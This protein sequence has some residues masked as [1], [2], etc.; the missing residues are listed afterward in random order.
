MR[1]RAMFTVW[2]KRGCEGSG[3]GPSHPAARCVLY[4][5]RVSSKESGLVAV[6]RNLHSQLPLALELRYTHTLHKHT[7]YKLWLIFP[8]DDFLVF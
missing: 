2:A 3:K 8:K 6:T 7:L 4:L 1:T 5:F